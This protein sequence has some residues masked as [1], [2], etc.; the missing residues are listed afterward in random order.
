MSQFR[1]IGVKRTKCRTKF[2]AMASVVSVFLLIF[3]ITLIFVDFSS[4]N[5]EKTYSGEFKVAA[6]RAV[7]LPRV[8]F[9]MKVWPSFLSILLS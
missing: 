3:G 5:E 1:T 8:S 4:E 6:I 7:L 2:I 9:V